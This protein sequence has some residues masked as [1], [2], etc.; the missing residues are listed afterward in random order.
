MSGHDSDADLLIQ[1][2]ALAACQLSGVIDLWLESKGR[3]R[4]FWAGSSIPPATLTI[5]K[6]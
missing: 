6:Y 4:R 1:T 3:V 5:S 2:K